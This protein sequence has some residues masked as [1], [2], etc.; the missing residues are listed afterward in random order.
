MGGAAM[1]HSI[2]AY[3]DV[4]VGSPCSMW[5][6]PIH[7]YFAFCK[8]ASRERLIGSQIEHLVAKPSVVRRLGLSA[9]Y[10]V[11]CIPFDYALL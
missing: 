9:R 1:A 2:E 4:D 5:G 8:V 11:Q 7:M 3:G 6:E 10:A